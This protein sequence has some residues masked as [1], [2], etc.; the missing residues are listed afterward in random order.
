MNNISKITI[1]FCEGPHDTAFLYR[2]LK[3]KCF[4]SFKDTLDKLPKVIGD[5]IMSKNRTAEYNLLKIDSLKNDF[6]PYKIMY[7]EEELILLYSLGGD[8]DGKADEDNKRLII[9]NHFLRNIKVN[10]E[11][12]DNLGEAFIAVNSQE[13]PFNYKFLFF[14]DADNDKAEKLKI[15]NNYLRKIDIE[16]ILNH[17]EIITKDGYLIGAYIFSNDE[18]KGS[19]EDILF[20]LMKAGNEVCFDKATEYYIQHLNKNNNMQPENRTKRLATECIDGVAADKR[21]DSK[22]EDEKKSVIC[23]AG[24]LQKKGKSNVVVIEDSDYLNLEKINNSDKAQE[25]ADFIN[26]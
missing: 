21:K 26:R 16:T 3:T 17:N 22:Q 6:V 15:I 5:F 18:D 4:I 13:Q 11:D 12:T 8:K 20:S 9:L 1:A 24:Q 2:I 14:Y 19:L 25:I 7:K 10:V 23:I